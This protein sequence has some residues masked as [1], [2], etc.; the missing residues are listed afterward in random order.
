M[1]LLQASDFSDLTNWPT[2]SEVVEVRM[3]DVSLLLA[4]G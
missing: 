4:A 1:S 2:L 3:D